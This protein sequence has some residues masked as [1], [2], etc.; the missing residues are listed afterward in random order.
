MHGPIF[1]QF[2]Q[3]VHPC[4]CG[5]L[6]R[7]FSAVAELLVCSGLQNTHLFCNRVRFGRSG[8]SKVDDFDTNRKRVATFY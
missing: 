1:I 8:S 5:Q 7:C 4:H 3:R 2:L 6:T